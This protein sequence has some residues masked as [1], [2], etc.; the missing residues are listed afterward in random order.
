MK[1]LKILLLSLLG[2]NL[3]AQDIQ[4]YVLT[5]L[6][7]TVVAWIT[8]EDA[9]SIRAAT[10]HY[11]SQTRPNAIQI[12][13]YDNYS[14]T[15]RFN[16]HSY[17]W[18]MSQKNPELANPRWI[19]YYSGNTDE[20]IY[21][22][23]GSY[24]EVANETYPGMVSWISDDHSAITTLTPG[25]WKSKWGSN[26]LA[27][28]N[29]NDCPYVTTNLKYYSPFKVD[30]PSCVCYGDEATFYTPD[31]VNCTYN[32]TYDTNLL[33]YVS[34]QGTRSFKVTPKNST[35]A[36]MGGVMLTLTI[37][38]P[39]NKTRII[40]RY[41][42]VNRPHSDNLELA[43]YTTGGSPVT[44]MCPETHYHIYLNNSGG[45][46]LSNYTWSIPS[47]WTQNYTWENMISVYT[48]STYGGMVEVYADACNGINSKVIIDYF[49]GGGYCG[50]SYSMV[51]SPNPATGETT[52]SIETT[53]EDSE[54][55][56]NAEWELEVYSQNQLLKEKKT[57]LRG[58]STTIPTSGWKE[59][60]YFVRVNYK[61]E[62]LQGKLVVKK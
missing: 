29:W 43:L 25:K 32:W 35:S 41:I 59:G 52:L 50:N 57:S 6:G 46:S 60:V 16:C 8:E 38:P 56:E 36:G 7:D 61:D 3:S 28:H 48:G 34:G 45:C 40:T 14:S 12:K 13:T 33:N 55:D 24:I 44:Y 39:V 21:W 37:D 30:N 47:G 54:F 49:G 19:G 4:S 20:H 2:F 17:A 22:E 51:L 10:D 58:S 11:Y 9:S 62:V 23:G 27:I 42:G 15:R 53:S 18:Y 31:Y 5:P 26:V 1:L